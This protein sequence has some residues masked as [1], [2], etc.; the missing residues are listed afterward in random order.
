[1]VCLYGSY[2]ELIFRV[3]QVNL[4]HREVNCIQVVDLEQDPAGSACRIVKIC[5]LG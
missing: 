1:M 3:G 5:W 4:V 2:S